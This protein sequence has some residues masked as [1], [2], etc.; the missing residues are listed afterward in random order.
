M[1][2]RLLRFVRHDLLRFGGLSP[3]CYVAMA[4]RWQWLALPPSLYR[5][6]GG[7]RYPPHSSTAHSPYLT[8]LILSFLSFPCLT[9]SPQR[10]P[11]PAYSAASAVVC[12]SLPSMS[13]SSLALG[14]RAGSTWTCDGCNYVNKARE[15][16]CGNCPALKPD[17]YAFHN[18]ASNTCM[19]KASQSLPSP[20]AFPTTRRPLRSSAAAAPLLA[21]D[22]GRC[23]RRS[24]MTTVQH[25][26]GAEEEADNETNE[27]S[28]TE[29]DGD[30]DS[31]DETLQQRYSHRPKRH[32]AHQTQQRLHAYYK[33]TKPNTTS[34]TP[35]LAPPT[36]EC[37]SHQHQSSPAPATK[38]E[39]VEQPPPAAVVISVPV[40]FAPP[41]LAATPFVPASRDETITLL[42][43]VHSTLA[44]SAFPT[45]TSALLPSR[46]AH[47]T[48]LCSFLSR[49]LADRTSAAL[50][51]AGRPGVG[52]TLTVDWAL[53]TTFGPSVA[54]LGSKDG[55]AGGGAAGKVWRYGGRTKGKGSGGLPATTVVTVNA[56]ALM[57][58]HGSFWCR[59]LALLASK[60]NSGRQHDEL[61]HLPADEALR[62]LQ[63]L[64]DN[65]RKRG[66]MIVLV[67]DEIDALLS[68]TT[69]SIATGSSSTAAVSG[70]SGGS[71]T[72]LHALFRLVYGASSC[73]VLLSI[74][75]S[76]TLL[77]S[78][79]ST[80]SATNSL[81]ERVVFSTYSQA[82]LLCILQERLLRCLP[83]P[84]ITSSASSTTCPSAS[85][86]DASPSPVALPF[87]APSALDFL[88]KATSKDTGDVRRCLRDCRHAIQQLLTTCTVFLASAAF[89][90]ASCQL[91][92][93]SLAR[94]KAERE[95]ATQ[96]GRLSELSV[97]QLH[98]LWVLALVGGVVVSKAG[99]CYRRCVSRVRSG[100]TEL[101][102]GEVSAVL[103]ML[104]SEGMVRKDKQGKVVRYVSVVSVDRMRRQ[105]RGDIW[106]TL[107]S[108]A[109]AIQSKA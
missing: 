66:E 47:L 14:L 100:L 6:T 15:N 71:F 37:L 86:L 96:H 63:Q 97:Q 64:I 104:E 101:S 11:R 91:T 26:K 10:V 76:I 85:I 40:A 107:W 52:K 53:Q 60:G 74:S 89:S 79:C 72:L 22:S 78:H 44:L 36:D 55:V 56:I 94:V 25:V 109:A 43:R 49:H 29:S 67:I 34:T 18:T 51:I 68:S 84:S 20:A 50:Y 90:P 12:I 42:N 80:L 23:K 95:A 17:P 73:V 41:P 103:E 32:C 3:S 16:E 21:A 99:E 46:S 108:K 9:H 92:V 87:F 102:G 31:D 98:V 93:S 69:S 81:P 83:A 54:V 4:V 7:P 59:L 24:S 88:C 61:L 75:N 77:D 62:R 27:T 58:G 35:T 28:R 33:A 38:P 30:S 70:G 106:E 8:L 39:A 5:V 105:L 48:H 65:T 57:K 82:D 2:R 13:R 1:Q 45:T 19:T